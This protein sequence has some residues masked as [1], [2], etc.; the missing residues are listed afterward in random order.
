MS[1]LREA[2]ERRFRAI[3]PNGRCDQF[4]TLEDIQRWQRLDPPVDPADVA[5]FISALRAVEH[6]VRDGT[7]RLNGVLLHSG[8]EHKA[9]PA[10]DQKHGKVDCWKERLEVARDGVTRGWVQIDVVED[11][12]E[13]RSVGGS[14]DVAGA[15]EL[16]LN[17][18]G[19]PTE[20]DKIQDAARNWL[21]SDA[22]QATSLAD[23]ARGLK[24]KHEFDS[25]EETIEDHVRE[26]WN[27]KPKKK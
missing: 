22:K 11:K 15:G 2:V 12:F 9:I 25:A 3:A 26:I 18:G 24:R 21:A 10:Y 5:H 13:P 7:L 8:Q 1:S 4:K 20:R 23:F 27:S 14:N 19:R 16:A 17:K 6:D